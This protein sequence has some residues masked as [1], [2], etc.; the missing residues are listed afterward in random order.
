VIGKGR[1][2]ARASAG[3]ISEGKDTGGCRVRAFSGILGGRIMPQKGE[4]GGNGGFPP[5][6][7]GFRL[8]EGQ[9]DCVQGAV[10]VFEE[11]SDLLHGG[12][13]LED[14]AGE[15]VEHVDGVED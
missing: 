11:C 1:E 13:Q 2:R 4:G 3:R 12:A 15:L 9:E 5:F 14:T 7:V 8:G 6:S 10:V